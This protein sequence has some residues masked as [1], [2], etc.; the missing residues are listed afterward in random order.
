MKKKMPKRDFNNVVIPGSLQGF[1]DVPINAS[2]ESSRIHTYDPENAITPGNPITFRCPGTDHETFSLPDTELYMRLRIL[3]HDGT[4]ME[5]ADDNL[6]CFEN[7][8]LSTVFKSVQLF[9]NDQ[10]VV[11]F[12]D[13]Y[14]YKG[15]FDAQYGMT[16]SSKVLIENMGW[17]PLPIAEYAANNQHVADRAQVSNRSRTYEVVGRPNLEFLSSRLELLT[18]V[19]MRFVFF[20]HSDAFCLMQAQNTA[21]KCV[22]TEATM[23][24]R[25]NVITDDFRSAIQGSLAVE[26]WKYHTQQA[27]IKIDNIPTGSTQFSRSD[28]FSHRVPTKIILELIRNTAYAGTRNESALYSDPQHVRTVA[29]QKDGINYPNLREVRIDIESDGEPRWLECYQTLT[30]VS[31][32]GIQTEN[33]LTLKPIHFTQGRWAWGCDLTKLRNRDG[34]AIRNVDLGNCSLRMTFGEGTPHPL[35]VVIYALFD[36]TLTIDAKRD[37]FQSYA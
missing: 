35:E 11:M 31:D 13:N 27:M 9:L 12:P 37:I 19:S 28:V 18:G 6:V 2:H 10:Q 32:R 30:D 24:L 29:I 20:P 36:T 16:V 3:R 33:A 8:P 25:K 22:I 21:Y 17:H 14:G 23:K 26:P 7:L 15:F 34:T 5:E 1:K 4:P